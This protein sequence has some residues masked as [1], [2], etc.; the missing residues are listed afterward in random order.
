MF[1]DWLVIVV[2]LAILAFIGIWSSKKIKTASSFFIS[3]RNFGKALMT[4]FTFG[5]GTNTDQ[6]VTVVSKTHVSGASGIWYQWLWLFA[7]PFYWLL[8]PLFR[9]MRAVTTA[10]YLFVRYGQSVAILFALVGMAQMSVNI[11][12][13]LKASSALITSVTSGAISPAFAIFALTGLFVFYGVLGGLKAAIITDFIQG[14]LTIVLSFLIL[15]FAL[16]AVGGLAGLR[17]AVDDPAV[18]SIVAPGEITLLYVVVIALNA[19]VG[20]V[21]S[22]YTMAMCGAGKSEEDARIGLVSGMFLKR[23]CTIAWVLTGLCGI[24]I[25]A[26][27]TVAP[28]YVWGFLARDFLPNVAPGLIGLF[29]ASMLAAVMSSC[30]CFMVSSA[31]LFTENIYK[32]LIKPGQDEKHY[33]LTGRI[34][35]VVVVISGI[36][37]AF[38]VSGVVQGLEVFWK[39]HA[40][41]GIA[42]W[43]SFFWRKATAA[44]AW[45]STLSGFA[46]WAFTSKI[47]LIGWDFNASIAPHLPDY[48]LHNVQLSLPWQMIFYLIVGLFMMVGVSLVTRP[49]DKEKLD[50]VYECLRTPVQKGEPEVEPL[51]LPE[52]TKPAPRSV[53]FDHPDFEIMKPRLVDSLGFLISWLGVGI[54]I[55]AFVWILR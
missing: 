36:I 45:A 21:T 13:T 16:K 25:Y 55:G 23:F 10:D 38:G 50:R 28:D 43:A 7:T 32:P 2:Y 51:T 20:W 18:F 42:I 35:S 33:I 5:T 1:I 39:V 48:M 6:A 54:L 53:L 29:V 17:A 9:R 30:D 22:P 46:A 27:Q 31:A 44:G 8:A 24:G 11:G 26:G 3:E 47:N 4:F 52:S 14:I 49:P 40:M 12:V 19:L 15:P 34:S 37:I 41:M